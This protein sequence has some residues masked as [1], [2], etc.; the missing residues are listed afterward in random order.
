RCQ[1]PAFRRKT[2]RFVKIR[3]YGCSQTRP[4]RPDRSSLCAVSPSAS[5]G[6]A[7]RTASRPI[8]QAR[9][10]SGFGLSSLWPARSG[11]GWHHPPSQDSNTL[12]QLMKSPA[13]LCRFVLPLPTDLG[14]RRLA[15]PLLS[16]APPF[17]TQAASRKTSRALLQLQR[18][19]AATRCSL[20]R[21]QS[22]TLVTMTF[23]PGWILSPVPFLR[24]EPQRF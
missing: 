23:H 8:H 21:L 24:S 17:C 18:G 13:I 7:A 3:H 20:P 22:V 10:A 16:V 2:P 14:R 4:P 9:G 19:V 11:P 12:G 6:P 1:A 5:P 15:V